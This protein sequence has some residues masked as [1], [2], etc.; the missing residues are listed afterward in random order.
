MNP[1]TGSW[2]IFSLLIFRVFLSDISFLRIFIDHHIRYESKYP[3]LRL[4]NLG[5]LGTKVGYFR[6][7]LIMMGRPREKCVS[8]L[9][10]FL[11]GHLWEHFKQSTFYHSKPWFFAIHVKLALK[12]L[13]FRDKKLKTLKCIFSNDFLIGMRS[14]SRF[15]DFWRFIYELN[16]GYCLALSFWESPWIRPRL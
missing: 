14:F 15:T 4:G 6:T 7:P 8:I 10:I 2:S 12:P 13:M 9:P 1:L 16:I 3:K 5:Y 11:G